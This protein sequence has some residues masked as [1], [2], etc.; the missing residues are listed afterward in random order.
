MKNGFRL[1]ALSLLL[2]LAA[3]ATWA[4]RDA[5][6]KPFEALQQ[7]INELRNRLNTLPSTA[8]LQQQIDTL[9]I[10]LD[11]LPAA[12]SP[13]A[14]KHLAVALPAEG[15]T[16][17]TAI[18]ELPGKWRLKIRLSGFPGSVAYELVFENLGPGSADAWARSSHGPSGGT[19]LA[20]VS[21]NRPVTGAGEAILT[22]HGF[23]GPA[24]VSSF[25]HGQVLADGELPV[26]FLVA[27][28]G[29]MDRP[30]TVSAQVVT[31][32]AP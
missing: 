1:L 21:T 24:V 2:S 20:T 12:A 4:D 19:N 13:V 15:T 23:G 3:P 31:S 9:R 5:L 28:S 8:G 22:G 17:D 30:V 18:V 25:I 6:G 16:V 10:R 27:V 11:N 7:Q 29:A 26:A 32:P 14:G